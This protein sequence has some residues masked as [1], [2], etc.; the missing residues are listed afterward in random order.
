MK[1]EVKSNMVSLREASLNYKGKKDITEL[2]KVP[3]DDLQ[4]YEKTFK[5]KQDQEIT[6]FYVELN[7]IQ[8]TVKTM[9]INKLKELLT[10]RPQTKIVR[11]TKDGNGQFSVIP[12]D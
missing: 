1:K 7:G 6:Y 11:F 9:A 10:N 2:E 5:N 12:L 4:V 3:V 8:Y